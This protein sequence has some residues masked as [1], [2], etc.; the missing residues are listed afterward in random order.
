LTVLP[1][2][3]SWDWEDYPRML[4]AA[5]KLVQAGNTCAALHANLTVA[6]YLLG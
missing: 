3:R 2:R 6:Y 4:E 5:L 1:K